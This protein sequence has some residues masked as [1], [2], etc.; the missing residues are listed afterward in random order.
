MDQRPS[1]VVN[2]FAADGT[3]LGQGIRFDVDPQHTKFAIS[4]AWFKKASLIR[5]MTG[6]EIRGAQLYFGP[7]AW[8]LDR[9]WGGRRW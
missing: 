1:D 4:H 9:L 8:V 5:D 7:S 6:H 2:V 3:P